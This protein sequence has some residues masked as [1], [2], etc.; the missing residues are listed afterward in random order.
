MSWI[1]ATHSLHQSFAGQGQGLSASTEVCTTMCMVNKTCCITISCLVTYLRCFLQEFSAMHLLPKHHSMHTPT[2]VVSSLPCPESMPCRPFLLK[3]THLSCAAQVEWKYVIID[4]A[5]RMKDRQSKLARD[6]DRFTTLRRL[7][8]TGTPLQN[9]LQELWSLLNLLLPEVS[10][11][12]SL[13]PLCTALHL[14]QL[15]HLAASL[16]PHE[17]SF[18][19]G[20]WPLCTALRSG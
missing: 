3:A 19:K 12:H 4:E 15:N 2:T 7:L 9:E 8:L 20:L 13:M 10:S 16:S 6:L 5:Q 14:L 1:Q 18:V 17:M 11:T